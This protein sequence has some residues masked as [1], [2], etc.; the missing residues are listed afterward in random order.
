MFAHSSL[1]A[2]LSD[3][4]R[5]AL[6]SAL[7][8]N[9]S[10]TSLCLGGCD[11]G[12]GA[13]GAAAATLAH[14]LPRNSTLQDLQIDCRTGFGSASSVAALLAALGAGAYSD[15]ISLGVT[16]DSLTI[17]AAGAAALGDALGSGGGR[18]TKLTLISCPGGVEAGARLCVEIGRGLREGGCRVPLRELSL[19]HC[20]IPHAGARLTA[21]CAA[22][23]MSRCACEIVLGN[24]MW[25]LTSSVWVS[26][27]CPQGQRHSHL[28]CRSRPVLS[29]PCTSEKIQTSAT[30]EARRRAGV[31]LSCDLVY[32]A[33]ARE[34]VFRD[35]RSLKFCA[36]TLRSSLVRPHLITHPQASLLLWRWSR[37][38]RTLAFERLV[39]STAASETPPPLCS[40]PLSLRRALSSLLPP[41][42]AGYST[43]D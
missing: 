21:C 3:A 33:C 4:A 30:Q 41:P 13:G 37:T 8:T 15:G 25:R 39:S 18:V 5:A 6:L 29:S 2:A 27:S 17:D 31:T 7:A 36:V 28:R 40:V 35:H 42:A 38:Q 20:S 12:G 10:L 16:L 32:D 19:Q 11:F 23:I 43:S 22:I 9:T 24:V 14:A 34:F 1:L 26:P